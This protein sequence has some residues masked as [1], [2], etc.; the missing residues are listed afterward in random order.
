MPLGFGRKHTPDEDI[1]KLSRAELL[2]MLI[3]QTRET[4]RLRARNKRLTRE[5]QECKENLERSASL[6]IVMNRLEKIERF[7]AIHVGFT[8]EELAEL[9]AMS[10][11]TR[12]SHNIK[13]V[14]EMTDR[15]ENDTP[16]QEEEKKAEPDE[17]AEPDTVAEPDMVI[18]PEMVVETAES[19]EQAEEPEMAEQPETAEAVEAAQPVDTPDFLL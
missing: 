13:A 14:S 9:E 16:Q 18:E 10:Q 17:V 12:G 4:D 11:P 15:E 19:P 1:K 6:Q 2:E 8:E 7:A 5:L 3:D